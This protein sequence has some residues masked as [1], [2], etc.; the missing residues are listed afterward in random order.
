VQ[1]TRT[2]NTRVG[3]ARSWG[4]LCA[5]AFAA[6][7][8]LGANPALAADGIDPDAEQVLR[9]MSKYLGGLPAYSAT[10]EIDTEVVDMAG[11]KLQF[12]SSGSFLLS[13]P[14]SFH[15]HRHT[16]T[17]AFE[18]FIDG[19]T[20]TL[21]SRDRSLYYQVAVSGSLDQAIDTFRTETGFEIPG[22]DLLYADPYPGLM[23]D[24]TSSTYVGTTWV[25]G[26]ECHQLAFRA[27]KVDWQLWVQ[28]GDKP[29]PMKYIIT[30]KWITGAPQFSVRLSD[31]DTQPKVPAG[32][33]TFTAPAGAKRLQSIR[34]NELGEVELDGVKQ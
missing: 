26:V 6:A 10:A 9:A 17:G 27:S 15:S 11:Q 34:V 12:S 29:V 4:I 22:A 28:T 1:E 23:T 8:G 2:G 3:R 20:M 18:F 7:M 30:T 16:A 14:G 5:A 13:R 32:Q 31:W 21:Y 19:K 24:V 33:F 25:N